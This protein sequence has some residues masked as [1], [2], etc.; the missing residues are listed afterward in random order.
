MFIIYTNLFVLLS[1]IWSCF[2]SPVFNAN[3]APST[4]MKRIHNIVLKM[5]LKTTD[6]GDSGKG[7]WNSPRTLPKCTS[8]GCAPQ[9]GLTQATTFILETKN[10]LGLKKSL[11]PK[12]SRACR[13]NGFFFYK[14]VTLSRFKLGLTLN[15]H[16]PSLINVC[17][18]PFNPL[19]CMCNLHLHWENF[20][21]MRITY[22][23]LLF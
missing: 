3:L 23:F 14:T 10:I 17:N 22:V 9:T 21:K 7:P 12:L 15:I 18:L 16:K 1:P 19:L 8:Q 11:S 13:E 2:V 6:N 20:K 4:V 5:L